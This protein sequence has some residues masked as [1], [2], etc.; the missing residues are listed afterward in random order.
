MLMLKGILLWNK[1]WEAGEIEG[2]IK[3][4]KENM[5]W[6]VLLLVQGTE[7]LE[8]AEAAVDVPNFWKV[9]DGDEFRWTMGDEGEDWIGY[10]DLTVKLKAGCM[11]VQGD[12]GWFIAEESWH[13]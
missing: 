11:R 3:R 1:T 5:R 8:A 10:E 2:V 9:V 12:E 6:N 13:M 4:V 7:D